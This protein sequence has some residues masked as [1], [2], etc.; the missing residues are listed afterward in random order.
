MFWVVF[1]TWRKQG[2]MPAEE[3]EAVPVI[4]QFIF[5][6]FVGCFFFGLG[7]A[8]YL[9][10]VFTNSLTFDLS[11]PAGGRVKTKKYVANIVVTVLLGLGMGF[12]V[13]AFVS[14]V[15]MVLG[16]SSGLANMLP[17]LGMVGLVQVIELWVLIWSPLERRFITS[18]LLAQG[19]TPAQLQ[20]GIPIG[21]SNPASGALKRVGAIEEDMGELWVEPEQLVY[22]GDGEHLTISRDQLA[23]IERKE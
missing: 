19:I 4:A 1:W 3:P 11:K 2:Q 16:F 9:I 14:P 18:R 12:A 17:V 6:L 21:L 5:G 22:R 20:T 15:L 8:G 23:R 10:V 13:S 7:I